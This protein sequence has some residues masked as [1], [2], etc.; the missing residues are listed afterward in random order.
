MSFL[1]TWFGKKDTAGLKDA[2]P[3]EFVYPLV[4]VSGK[5][6]LD[7]WDEYQR[8]WQGEG[9]SAIVIGSRDEAERAEIIRR[10]SEFG[11]FLVED[12]VRQGLT[13]DIPALWIRYE[14]DYDCMAELGSPE[15]EGEWPL[16]APKPITPSVHL[17]G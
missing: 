4:S 10:N 14:N 8:Q 6:V 9:C 15:L 16:S 2:A 12:I 3:P 5:D 11:D 13:I 1:D 7:K 17:A